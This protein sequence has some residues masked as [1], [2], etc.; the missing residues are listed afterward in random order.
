L[1]VRFTVAIVGLHVL[2]AQN[3]VGLQHGVVDEWWSPRPPPRT[4]SPISRESSSPY[5]FVHGNSQQATTATASKAVGSSY[6]AQAELKIRLVRSCLV[7]L[8]VLLQWT[9][10]PV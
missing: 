7:A 8:E 10:K 3:L 5:F 1:L 2:V 6:M 4:A 9:R